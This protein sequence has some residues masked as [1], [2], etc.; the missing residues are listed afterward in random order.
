[1]ATQRGKP[2]QR[3]EIAANAETSVT[4]KIAG[5]IV[6]WKARQFH[7]QSAAAIDRP[8][9]GDAGPGVSGGDRL[10]DAAVGIEPERLA[11]LAPRPAEA[12]G[13][14]R[15]DQAGEFTGV[16][17]EASLCIHPPREA[18]RLLARI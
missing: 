18:Q 9:Q 1:M 5:A 2:R 13:G 7:R 10:E 14:A 11:D 8:A 6:D 3:I 4:G 12:G 17:R 16:E 15:A